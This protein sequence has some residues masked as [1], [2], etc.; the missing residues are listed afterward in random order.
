MFTYLHFCEKSDVCRFQCCTDLHCEERDVLEWK[1]IEH[2]LKWGFLFAGGTFICGIERSKMYSSVL[3]GLYPSG[4]SGRV[5]QVHPTPQCAER[6]DLRYGSQEGVWNENR[7]REVWHQESDLSGGGRVRA[8][9]SHA[10]SI[11]RQY[12][13]ED[14]FVKHTS[15]SGEMTTSSVTKVCMRDVVR[16]VLDDQV[17]FNETF[18]VMCFAKAEEALLAYE[19]EVSPCP[20]RNTALCERFL[21]FL[22]N[23]PAIRCK[24]H[25][26]TG[27]LLCDLPRCF[28]EPASMIYTPPR[29]NEGK[30]RWCLRVLRDQAEGPA[31]GMRH[32]Q[33][34]LGASEYVALRALVSES[35]TMMYNAAI[36]ANTAMHNCWL[37]DKNIQEFVSELRLFQSWHYGTWVWWKAQRFKLHN[38]TQST[39]TPFQSSSG[40]TVCDS[41]LQESTHTKVASARDNGYGVINE[42]AR[43]SQG[44]TSLCAKCNS[45]DE[46]KKKSCGHM[47]GNTT[48]SINDK[49]GEG[50]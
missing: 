4:Q 18:Y 2:Y 21:V 6:K 27:I 16:G 47:Q 36:S 8:G 28:P 32:L 45:R 1:K 15:L 22:Q 10:V 44:E 5:G 3:E 30:V 17:K 38:Y 37:V 50:E 41:S 14:R 49:V 24:I 13:A 46:E 43:A 7:G 11:P 12:P 42:Q 26:L 19:R 34:F 33:N 35:F 9:S 31:A 23:L 29:T 39:V 40:G 25:Q 20:D 48:R